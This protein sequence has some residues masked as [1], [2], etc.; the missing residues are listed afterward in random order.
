MGCQLVNEIVSDFKLLLCPS[1][2]Y[3]AV[4]IFYYLIRFISLST[5]E[6]SSSLNFFVDV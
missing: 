4:A 6:E 2:I 5:A 1:L 3:P